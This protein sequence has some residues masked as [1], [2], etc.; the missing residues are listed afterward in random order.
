MIST[1]LPICFLSI[2][3]CA[4]EP[5]CSIGNEMPQRHHRMGCVWQNTTLKSK[6]PSLFPSTCAR[7]ISNLY[8]VLWVCGGLSLQHYCHFR[9]HKRYHGHNTN[10]KHGHLA[11]TSGGR[12]FDLWPLHQFGNNCVNWR[13]VAGEHVHCHALPRPWI[14]ARD[15]LKVYPMMARFTLR[16]RL[17]FLSYASC[18]INRRCKLN[19]TT[20]TTPKQLGHCQSCLLN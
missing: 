9:F 10:A 14:L 19:A 20:T 17:E 8:K 15:P 16:R 7:Y 3:T 2:S 5:D 4:G 13:L 6:T 12:R 11:T 1:K 18:L